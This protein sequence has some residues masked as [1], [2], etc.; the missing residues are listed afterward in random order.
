MN[1]QIA[2]FQATKFMQIIEVITKQDKKEFID[3][4]KGLY[5]GEPCWICQLDSGIESVFDPTT[6]PAF[7]HGEAVRWILKDDND[8]IIGRIAAFIDR[9]RSDANNQ[10]TGGVGFFEVIEDKEAAF[11]LFE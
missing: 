5:K 4:P 2:V 10:P 7:R 9:V 1:Q 6:N 11:I 3:F 8:N